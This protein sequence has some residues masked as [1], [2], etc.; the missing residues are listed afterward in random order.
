MFVGNGGDIKKRPHF[1]SNLEPQGI[2]EGTAVPFVPDSIDG[3]QDWAD[4]ANLLHVTLG[5]LGS[6]KK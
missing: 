2:S 4:V 6:D 3:I 1:L 5:K